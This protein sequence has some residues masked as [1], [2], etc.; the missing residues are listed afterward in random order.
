MRRCRSNLEDQIKLLK[1]DIRR[2]HFCAQLFIQVQEEK[3]RGLTPV[4]PTADSSVLKTE[5]TDVSLKSTESL[6]RELS[7][8]VLHHNGKSSPSSSPPV[9]KKMASVEIQ[10]DE[11]DIKEEVL[12]EARALLKEAGALRHQHQSASGDMTSRP[13]MTS[14]MTQANEL[15]ISAATLHQ[16]AA[17]TP[18]STCVPSGST[19]GVLR[20]SEMTTLR[21]VTSSTSSNVLMTSHAMVG[22]LGTS[23]VV[24]VGG[25]TVGVQCSVVVN[26]MAGRSRTSTESLV[27]GRSKKRKMEPVVSP[28][29]GAAGDDSD[30]DTDLRIVCDEEC[31]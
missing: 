31:I 1:E 29:D 7:L 17:Y 5:E 19:G 11:M 15:D 28:R 25:S 8:P 10:A 22:S 2:Q 3:K 26:P 27:A 12:E 6:P 9:L 21:D 14:V 16:H 24:G 20:R 4:V 30:S 18:L 23:G 13:L